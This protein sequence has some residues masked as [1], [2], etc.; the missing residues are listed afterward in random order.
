MTYVFITGA[1]GD[2]GAAC[3]RALAKEGYSLYCHY[4]SNEEKIRNLVTEL[5]VAYPEQDFLIIQADLS[6]DSSLE[7]ITQSVFQLD[8]IIFAHGDTSYELLTTHTSNEF[9]DMWRVHLK[10]PMRLCQ[11]FQS[12]LSQQQQGRIVFISS[13]Y[14]LSGS[15]MEVLYS[16]L[17][18][19][20]IA[21][22]NA[23]AKEVASL[24]ITVNTIAPGAVATRMNTDW[25]EEETKELLETIPVNRMALPEEIASF[26]SF[27]FKK[28]ASYITGTTLPM[29]GGWKI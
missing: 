2:I 23:Y 9:D 27:L 12:K 10:T 13:I 17:K 25:T 22:A 24:G 28:E 1:S 20:Q 4:H 16:T 18:G 29:T 8:G 3:A 21:F 19:G 11:A 5:K 26:A 6:L 15:S 7:I 14:G